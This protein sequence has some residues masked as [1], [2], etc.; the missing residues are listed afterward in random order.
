MDSPNVQKSKWP[1]YVDF[2]IRLTLLV[3]IVM[4]IFLG[5]WQ[6]VFGTTGIFLVILLPTLLREKFNVHMPRRIDASVAIFVFLSVFLGSVADFYEKFPWW[7]GALHFKSGLL[8]G[9]LGFLVVYSMNMSRPGKISMSPGFIAFF[10][11]CFSLAV[12]VF[13]EIYEY[14]MD[15]W[16][17]YTMQETGLPDTM[18]DLI[19]NAVGA[20]IIGVVSYFWMKK[21]KT[22]PFTPVSIKE[23][24]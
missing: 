2:L 23:T 1:S 24:V 7:D 16:F 10:S 6:S 5:D 8:L 17:G 22:V 15:T 11:V 12:S 3:A 19:I 4:Y 9:I 20:I 14:V 21:E 18:G 13:W